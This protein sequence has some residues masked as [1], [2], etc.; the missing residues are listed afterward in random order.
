M[1]IDCI[2]ESQDGHAT[3]RPACPIQLQGLLRCCHWNLP[4]MWTILSS[5]FYCVEQPK[6]RMYTRVRPKATPIIKSLQTPL[7]HK[8]HKTFNIFS[9]PPTNH[10]VIRNLKRFHGTDFTV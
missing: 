8:K 2:I 3:K 1:F 4:T 6:L 5:L 10:S 7:K 9:E